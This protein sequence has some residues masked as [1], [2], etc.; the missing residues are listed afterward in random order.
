MNRSQQ[1]SKVLVL[2]MDGLD[3]R[4][5][6]RMVREGRL[7]A[8]GRL[9]KNGTLRPLATSNPAES[10]VAW[11]S[12][13][14]GCN[15]GKHGIFD[16]IHRHPN[17]YVPYLSLLYEPHK[18]AMKKSADRYACPRA[19]PG[20][21]RMTSDAGLPT[22]VVRWPVTFPAE[23]V[24]GRF[25][26]GLGVPDATGRLGKYTYYTTAR[27]VERDEK[28]VSVKW[29]SNEI[30]TRVFGP[31]VAGL[32]G[33]RALGVKLNIKRR[34]NGLSLALGSTQHNVEL[35]RWSDWFSV[36]F[37]YG[38]MRACDA[39]VKFHLVSVEPELRLF[40][41]PM[42]IHPERQVWPL[43]QPASYGAELSEAIG[44]FYT[45]GLPEDTNGV[46]DGRYDLDAF[47]QQCQEINQQRRAMFEHELNRFD[48]GALAFV[49]DAGDRI[50]HMFWGIDDE[51]SPTFDSAAAAKYG[52]V[53]DDLYREMDA[54]L[55]TALTAEGDDTTVFVV[56][57][58]GFGPF[59][60]AV[61]LNRWLIDNGYM[62]LR[63]ADEGRSLLADVDW[64]QTKA[65]AVG[66]TSLYLNIADRESKGIVKP[67]ED[68]EDLA[69]E[70]SKR[71]SDLCDPDTA[72]S[73]VRNVYANRDI[74]GGSCAE[75]GPD[76]VVG[77]E[78]G[79]RASWQTALGGA[80][81]G[82]V[83]DNDKAWSADHLVDPTA[84]P[85]VLASNLALNDT[86]PN[87]I[88]LAPT[89]L[90]CLDLPVPSNM[91][92]QSW[93]RD[94]AAHEV[95]AGEDASHEPELVSAMSLSSSS[96]GLNDDQRAE[97]EKHLGDLGYL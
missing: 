64:T 1:R 14:T 90:H 89:I 61:H 13:A 60:R 38:P 67:G 40:A 8:F 97:L 4:R 91:D 69:L 7:P 54:I 74:Y 45:L 52:H 80:P 47:L 84:V 26:S 48:D 18:S 19:V 96:D 22:T 95:A 49:F 88:D 85:G 35:G 62:V 41:T 86:N 46:T 29:R 68:A 43:T 83:V 9:Q 50:Q 82:T 31:H 65:Y 36:T 10:P 30:T 23:T 70:I 55:D 25:L 20:F 57:D 44:P 56:S 94:Q 63:G 93:L 71:L 92:G 51:R 81:H 73:A 59:R 66:F 6:E 79:Y 78:P 33:S 24:N 5:V 27:D 28:V 21:W 72:D 3:P 42:Q 32:R 12:L 37:K 34:A 77:F 16:F 39:L 53:V 76:L 58:H 17:G 75:H 11:S 2:G 87:G 15:P